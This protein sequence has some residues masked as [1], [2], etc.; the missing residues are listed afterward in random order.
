VS[1]VHRAYPPPRRPL[2]VSPYFYVPPKRRWWPLLA[3]FGVGGVCVLALL[4]PSQPS[5]D[6]GAKPVAQLVKPLPKHHT[7]RLAKQR[8]AAQEAQSAAAEPN[9]AVGDWGLGAAPMPAA[10]PSELPTPTAAPPDQPAVTADSAAPSV[11]AAKA[12]VRHAA[13]STHRRV[14]KKSRRHEDTWARGYDDYRGYRR[15][16]GFAGY[17]YG[18]SWG[19]RTRTMW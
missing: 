2:H 5:G 6:A 19:G 9:T 18:G 17:G 8:G 16:S 14:A 10:T 7:G 13:K 1:I 12:P 3:A 11:T 4:G 15:Y